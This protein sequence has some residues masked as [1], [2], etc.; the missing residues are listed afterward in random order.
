MTT[1]TV[2][3]YHY[4]VNHKSETLVYLQKKANSSHNQQKGIIW[5]GGFKS[6]MLGSKASALEALA[7][8][9]HY[10]YLR[11]DYFGH[12]MSS[13]EFINGTISLW[14]ENTL[15]MIDKIAQGPQ[16]LVG[17]SM[18]GW[19]ALLAALQRPKRIKSLFLI[20]P[21]PDFTENLI[22]ETLDDPVR[23]TL[24]N[25]GIYSKPSEYDDEPYIITMKLIEDARQHLLLDSQPDSIPINLPIYIVQGLK[26]E[27]VPW[28]HA[29]RILD[30]VQSKHV[31]FHLLK[32]GDHRL[33]SPTHL[34]QVVQQFETFLQN[35]NSLS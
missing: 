7:V 21:A 33:S 4:D 9:Y 10:D 19:L 17:S 31:Q 6:D 32:T 14:L 29:L 25:K 15:S 24:K 16:I 8:K 35:N 27:D 2:K 1:Q 28:L 20:A 18:G 22:W 26:D 3:K 12:G 23:E 11:F 34:K 30:H 5:L 13:G